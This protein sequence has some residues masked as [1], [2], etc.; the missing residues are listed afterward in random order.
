[1]IGF[2][3][4]HD[5]HAV[6]VS[7][8]AYPDH[9]ANEGIVDGII[10]VLQDP[11]S[12][13]MNQIRR[14]IRSVSGYQREDGRFGF[15]ATDN[16]YSYVPLP[17]LKDEAIYR[18]LLSCCVELKRVVCEGDRERIGDL[19]DCLHNLPIFLT[20]NNYRIPKSFWKNEVKEYRKKWDPQFLKEKN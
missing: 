2:F 8:R 3:D 1:M 19:A 16:E 15:A 17:F 20:E 14:A 10:A 7:I 12:C 13:G 5:L 9:P 11:S 4:L 6:F 18:V